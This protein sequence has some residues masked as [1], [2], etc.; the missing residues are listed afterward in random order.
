[1]SSIFDDPDPVISDPTK[2]NAPENG[3]LVF[4]FGKNDNVYEGTLNRYQFRIEEY[5]Y[6]ARWECLRVRERASTWAACD[7]DTF[8]AL[9][10]NFSQRLR[11]RQ[12]RMF[13]CRIGTSM[14][15]KWNADLSW[16]IDNTTCEWSRKAKE[17]EW[18]IGT[19]PRCSLHSWNLPPVAVSEALAR[20]AH[21]HFRAGFSIPSRFALFYRDLVGSHYFMRGN[22]GAATVLVNAFQSRVVRARDRLDLIAMCG[23]TEDFLNAWFNSRNLYVVDPVDILDDRS[24][25]TE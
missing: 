7:F 17:V 18:A 24:A 10:Q 16:C 21:W 4:A 6:L 25:L 19:W 15:W 11:S 20:R 5:E 1:M 13:Q 14:S 12:G 2:E 9:I 8:I 3:P 23:T 22:A